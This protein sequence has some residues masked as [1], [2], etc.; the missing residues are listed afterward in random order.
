[1]WGIGWA[2]LCLQ[3]GDGVHPGHRESSRIPAAQGPQPSGGEVLPW[4]TS[5]HL[6]WGAATPGSPDLHRGLLAENPCGQHEPG[7][8][9][10]CPWT[11]VGPVLAIHPSGMEDASWGGV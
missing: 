9:A 8:W 5:A 11:P 7:W 3:D 10:P 4:G 6:G 1:M 2:S